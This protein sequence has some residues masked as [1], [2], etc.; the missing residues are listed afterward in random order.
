[1]HDSIELD[2]FLRFLDGPP[3]IVAEGTCGQPESFEPRTVSRKREEPGL[4]N[5]DPHVEAV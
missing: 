2:P 1:M 3:H 4:E 5:A